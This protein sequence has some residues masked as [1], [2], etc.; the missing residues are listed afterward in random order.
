MQLDDGCRLF[1]PGSMNDTDN[2]FGVLGNFFQKL[3]S[4]A[5]A[6]ETTPRRLSPYARTNWTGSR[7]EIGINEKSDR[8]RGDKPGASD[9]CAAFFGGLYQSGCSY[10]LAPHQSERLFALRE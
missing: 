5:A 6:N 2:A 10:D 4:G 1:V 7:R 9:A 3:T 8:H